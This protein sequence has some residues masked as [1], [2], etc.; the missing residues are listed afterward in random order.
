[1]TNDRASQYLMEATLGNPDVITENNIEEIYDEMQRRA[2]EKL[3]REKDDFYTAKIDALQIDVEQKTKAL[4]FLESDMHKLQVENKKT[5]EALASASIRSVELEGELVSQNDQI[6]Q[7]KSLVNQISE[8]SKKHQLSADEIKKNARSKA[9]QAA[10]KKI[11]QLRMLGVGLAALC[12]I[13]I[14]YFDKFV[15][16]QLPS[17]SQPIANA[18]YIGLGALL[19]VFTASIIIEKPSKFIFS[20]VRKKILKERLEE[21]GI[22]DD[23]PAP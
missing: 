5:A 4:S 6:Q 16:P 7:L 1:M 11:Q 15:I 17:D 8:D 10:D 23:A 9:E 2:V 12:A 21:L 18:A 13:L 14:N 19:T 22:F 3:S 20:K